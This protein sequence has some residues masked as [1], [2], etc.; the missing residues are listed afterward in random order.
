MFREFAPVIGVEYKKWVVKVSY[1]FVTGTISNHS[2]G[3]AGGIEMSVV[4]TF[5]CTKRIAPSGAR[6]KKIEAKQ[7][8][9]P[10]SVSCPTFK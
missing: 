10:T 7:W 2:T 3:L 1:D 5:K 9:N 8:A 6:N 4:K